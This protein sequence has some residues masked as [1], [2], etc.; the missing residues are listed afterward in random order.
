M[1]RGNPSDLQGYLGSWA[2]N[3]FTKEE[4]EKYNKE[5]E[6]RKQEWLLTHNNNEKRKKK[7]N[8]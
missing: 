1:K 5:L 6:V 4:E 2:P 3:V 8:K 7:K